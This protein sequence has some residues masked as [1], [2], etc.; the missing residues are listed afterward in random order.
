MSLPYFAVIYKEAG[1]SYNEAAEC[2]VRRGGLNPKILETV[3]GAGYRFNKK[4]LD[5][6][7]ERGEVSENGNSNF[8]LAPK[9]SDSNRRYY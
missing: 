7:L 2:P 4:Y 1:K 5:F 9:Y 6:N 3:W 8:R